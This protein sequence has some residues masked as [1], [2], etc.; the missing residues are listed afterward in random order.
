[1]GI[2]LQTEIR[3]SSLLGLHSLQYQSDR[4]SDGVTRQIK[5]SHVLK[6]LEVFKRSGRGCKTRPAR[7]YIFPLN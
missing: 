3:H 4:V 2:D 1:M 5:V 6:T 7:A